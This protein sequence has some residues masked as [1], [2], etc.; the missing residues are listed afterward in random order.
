VVVEDGDAL[1]AVAPFFADRGIARVTRYRLLGNT[2]RDILIDPRRGREASGAIAE[3]LSEV[4]PTPDVFSLE[5]VTLAREWPASL[6]MRVQWASMRHPRTA[7]CADDR[8][9]RFAR[10]LDLEQEP[11]LRHAFESRAEARR[12]G[13]RIR[14]ALD[15]E[16]EPGLHELFRGITPGGARVLIGVEPVPSAWFFT[17]LGG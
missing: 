14:P 13:G 5:S 9:W 1:I 6:R 10:T 2:R 3:V 15:D 7:A 4:R 11:E 17:L 12:A 8:S 16:V